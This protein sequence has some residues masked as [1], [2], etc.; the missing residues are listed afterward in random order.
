MLFPILLNI[1][2]LKSDYLTEEQEL[3]QYIIIVSVSQVQ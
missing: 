1:S 2:Y 3:N